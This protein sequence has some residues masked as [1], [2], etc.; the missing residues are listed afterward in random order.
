MHYRIKLYSAIVMQLVGIKYELICLL[1]GICTIFEHDELP[2]KFTDLGDQDLLYG[3][4]F[5]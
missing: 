1:H 4:L 3:P 5:I 2:P